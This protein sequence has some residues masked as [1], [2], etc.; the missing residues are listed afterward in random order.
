MTSS[1]FKRESWAED[2]DI[3]RKLVVFKTVRLDMNMKGN[4]WRN[5]RERITFLRNLQHQE[6]REKGKT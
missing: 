4:A 3:V 6:F 2:L 5:R 1:G